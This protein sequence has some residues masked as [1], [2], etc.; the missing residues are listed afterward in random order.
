MKSPKNV[1][2]LNTAIRV[3]NFIARMQRA[4]DKSGARDGSGVGGAS[5]GPGVPTGKTV[6]VQ[7]RAGGSKRTS[8][9]S[10]NGKMK[11]K[12]AV[13]KSGGRAE[14]R[15]GGASPCSGTPTELTVGVRKCAGG[16]EIISARAASS[17]GSAYLYPSPPTEKTVEIQK[18]AGGRKKISGDPRREKF[19]EQRLLAYRIGVGQ[20]GGHSMLAGNVFSALSRD[21]IPRSGRERALVRHRRICRL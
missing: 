17:V 21:R 12:R 16:G 9:T 8:G 13:G 6:E 4:I 11:K 10:P 7:R 20:K 1:T 19:W 18:C 15:V 2:M 3:N 14:R 5:P